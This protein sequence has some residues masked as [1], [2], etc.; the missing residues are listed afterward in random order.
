MVNRISL[1]QDK[2]TKTIYISTLGCPRNSVD[3]EVFYNIAFQYGY[4]ASYDREDADIILINTCGFISEAIDESIQDIFFLNSCRK[5]SSKLIVTGCL[6]KLAKKALE[7]ELP[8]VDYFVDLKD[9][10]GFS[11][12]LRTLNR[13]RLNQEAAKINLDERKAIDETS[14]AYLKIS[15]GCNNYCSYCLIPYIRGR[16]I[17]DKPEKLVLEAKQIAERGVK[18]LILTSMDVTKYGKGLGR[19]VDILYLLDKLSA[20][21]GIEWIRLLYLHPIGITDDLIKYV[22]DNEKVCNYFDIPIQH[23]NDKILTS[24]N[25]NTTRKEIECLIDKIRTQ[26]PD[27]ALRTSL[28]VGYPGEKNKE[29][30]ELLS[31]LAATK[32][33]RLG[34]FNYSRQSITPSSKYAEQ[35]SERT[36]LRRKEEL[37]RLQEMISEEL[38][39]EYIGKTIP[40]IIDYTEESEGAVYLEGR[41]RYDAPEIDGV[42][43]IEGGYFPKG[44]IVNVK[45]T[46]SN[47]YDLG[48]EIAK[49]DLRLIKR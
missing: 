29:F 24:M 30:K 31:F 45:I 22:R 9:Y 13:D 5:E 23:I 2:K 37:M 27:V 33:N 47:E 28:I 1:K 8:E 15:D 11:T 35:V 26:I 20:V 40:V 17:C 25:R 36:A 39:V 7:G 3:S 49:Q 18:E 16:L 14:Y 42:V 41:T 43:D 10:K 4:E 34:V 19:K 6:I 38:L 44:S 12:L 48:G 21:E 32:F 46:E